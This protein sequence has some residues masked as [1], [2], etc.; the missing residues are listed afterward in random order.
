MNRS[1]RGLMAALVLAVPAGC[2]MTVAP[3]A[4]HAPVAQARRPAPAVVPAGLTPAATFAAVV[5]RVEPVAEAACRERAPFADCDF[6]IVVDDRPDAPPNAF[7]TR[8]PATGRPVIA[9]TASLIRSAANADELAFVLGH[10]AAHHIAGHLDRQRDTAV[11][12]AMVAGALAAALGQR[13]AGSL[14]TAQNIGATLGARTF[15]KDY[16]LEADTGGTVIAWQAGFDPLRG[17]AF[18]DRMPDPGNQFLGTHPPN[19]ARID[20]V[21]RTLAVLEGGG[22][23]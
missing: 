9:F 3:D 7:Q 16:E 22:R 11:A 17:A 23:V 5:A 14:R 6:L 10:E 21:R 8:D 2:G 19:S 4:G 20:T 1:L 18:F 15:S 12:G 13:D